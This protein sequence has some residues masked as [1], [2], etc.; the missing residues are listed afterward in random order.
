MTINVLMGHLVY[1]RKTIT[2]GGCMDK[3]ILIYG[4]S[5]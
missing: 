2:K 1:V 3:K 4:K 5:G